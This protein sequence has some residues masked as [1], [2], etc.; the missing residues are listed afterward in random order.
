MGGHGNKVSHALARI[1][2][3]SSTVVVWLKDVLPDIEALVF[4]DLSTV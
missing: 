3:T 4:N 1:A 2:L